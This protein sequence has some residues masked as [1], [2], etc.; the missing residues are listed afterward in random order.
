MVVQPLRARDVAEVVGDLGGER[1]RHYP[2][3]V[4]GD[5]R[6]VVLGEELE[7]AARL[8]APVELRV[9][10]REPGPPAGHG[11]VLVDELAER[12]VHAL[13]AAVLAA[14]READDAERLQRVRLEAVASGLG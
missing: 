7:L 14:Q 13:E 6:E 5:D 10:H 11:R 9:E 12:V 1:E 3:R 2:V 4:L 8:V